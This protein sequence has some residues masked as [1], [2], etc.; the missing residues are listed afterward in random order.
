MRMM[1]CNFLFLVFCCP[2]LHWE[3]GERNIIFYRWTSDLIWDMAA[4]LGA[5]PLTEANEERVQEHSLRSTSLP[6]FKIIPCHNQ[7]AA[8]L[9]AFPNDYWC[10]VTL[11]RLSCR[12][13][14][15]TVPGNQ[16]LEVCCSS[17]LRSQVRTK[18][19]DLMP[20]RSRNSMGKVSSLA[21]SIQR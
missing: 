10:M 19:N 13:V 14:K 21:L 5:M 1:I 11:H 7:K 8:L 17:S 18:L 9:I 15:R 12:L 20:L 2:E 3:E 6:P 4:S 16:R